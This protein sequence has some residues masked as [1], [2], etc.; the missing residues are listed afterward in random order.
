MLYCLKK[1][2]F[3]DRRRGYVIWFGRKS[4]SI[5]TNKLSIMEKNLTINRQGAKSVVGVM[6]SKMDGTIQV[7]PTRFKKFS[8]L[9]WIRSALSEARQVGAEEE[10][11][12]KF[13]SYSSRH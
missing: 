10:F 2:H 9:S 12:W 11:V 13:L 1:T 3:T 4:W 6:S 5:L 8:E 7:F